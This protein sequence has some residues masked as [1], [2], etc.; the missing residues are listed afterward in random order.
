MST[1]TTDGLV[2]VGLEGVMD[3]L[4]HRE[5]MLFVDSVQVDVAKATGTGKWHVRPDHPVFAGHYPDLPIFPGNLIAE[6]AAQSAGVVY[7]KTLGLS[8]EGMPLLSTTSAT[9]SGMVLPGDLL[10]AQICL[11]ESGN[12]MLAS[13]VCVTN[14]KTEVAHG[15]V[16]VHILSPRMIERLRINMAKLKPPESPPDDG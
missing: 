7:A 15:S 11:T 4:P 12:K 6:M 2:I 13:Y 16:T 8:V 14:G 3:I 5:P 10:E 1:T 9:F